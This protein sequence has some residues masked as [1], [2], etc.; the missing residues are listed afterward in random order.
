MSL[1]RSVR[2]ATLLACALAVFATSAADAEVKTQA[3]GGFVVRN[4]ATDPMMQIL[5]SGTVS[6]PFLSNAGQED[7]ALCFRSGA[8]TLG[9]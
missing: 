1:R 3:A 7:T 9:R 4:S 5:T 6:F 8:G 2:R